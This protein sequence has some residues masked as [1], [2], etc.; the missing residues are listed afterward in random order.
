MI[1][2]KFMRRLALPA[3]LLAILVVNSGCLVR[4]IRIVRKGAPPAARLLTVSLED[5]LQRL[6]A[7]DQQ[8]RTINATVDLEPSLG[9]VNKSEITELKDLRAFVLIRKPNWIRMIG[10]YPIVRNRAFDMVSDGMDFKI[11]FP[12]RNQFVVG[13]NRLEKP[14][15]KKLENIR[16]QHIFDALVVRPPAAGEEAVLENDTDEINASYILHILRQEKGRLVL[17]RN[18]SFHRI[19]LRLARQVIFDDHGDIVTDAR[20]EDYQTE[21][22]L[23][24][25]RRFVISRPLDEYGVKLTVKKLELNAALDDEKFALTPPPG[26]ELINISSPAPKGA[27]PAGNGVKPR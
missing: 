11:Y 15:P 12:A 22:G 5:L 24:F 23:S 14:S 2:L 25:P 4:R 17:D 10:L 9:T 7:W 6:N 19:N 26:T 20:Y 18:L 16:P 8:V 1:L 27:T 21:K 13:K 3:L